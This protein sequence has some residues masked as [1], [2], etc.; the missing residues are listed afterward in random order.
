MNAHKKSDA[1]SQNEDD[2]TLNIQLHTTERKAYYNWYT[3]H[4]YLKNALHPLIIWSS[5]QH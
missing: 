4:L 3:W 5:H 2:T 1:F